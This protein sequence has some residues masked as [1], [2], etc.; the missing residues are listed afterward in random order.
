MEIRHL[1]RR[2][3]A[4]RAL[5]TIVLASLLFGAPPRPA[6]PVA[7]SERPAVAHA[8]TAEAVGLLRQLPPLIV[9]NGG[10]LDPRVAYV[11]AG[12]HSTVFLTAD[13]LT[14]TLARPA[15][16]AGGAETS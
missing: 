4:R 11:V 8:T 15:E 6:V 9:E 13:G 12:K 16:T 7:A 5:T 10:R 2:P 14:M 1:W 3:A